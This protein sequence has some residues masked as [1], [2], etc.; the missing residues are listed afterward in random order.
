MTRGLVR[1]AALLVLSIASLGFTQ[2]GFVPTGSITVECDTGCRVEMPAFDLVEEAEPRELVSLGGLPAGPYDLT[3]TSGAGV[4]DLTLDVCGT[5]TPIRVVRGEVTVDAP[6]CAP[7]GYLTITLPT[8]ARADVAQRTLRTSTTVALY[9]GAYDVVLTTADGDEHSYTVVVSR[10][11]VT[12]VGLAPADTT[13]TFVGVPQDAIIRIS[14]AGTFDGPGPHAVAPGLHVVDVAAPGYAS[15][16]FTLRLETGARLERAIELEPLPP[17]FARIDV[18]PA[19]ATIEIDGGSY[20]SGDTITLSPGTFTATVTAPGHEATTTPLTITSET[21]TTAE[22]RLVEIL[23]RLVLS[24]EPD[25]AEVQVAGSQYTAADNIQLTPNTYVVLVTAPGFEPFEGTVDIAPDTDTVLEVSLAQRYV[26]TLAGGGS[27]SL[28]LRSDG[29]VWAWGSNWG[30]TLG[31]GTDTNRRTPVQ[32]TGLSDVTTISAGYG[33]SL[34]QRS[35]GTVWAWGQGSEGRLGDGATTNRATPVQVTGLSDVTAISAGYG[36]SLALR[37]DGTVWAWGRNR[38]GQLGDGTT[39]D[40]HVPVRVTGLSGVTAISAGFGHSLAQ[41]SDGTVWAWG[42]NGV[43][44]LG[45]GSATDRR[46][47]V[48][49]SGLSNATAVSAGYGFSLALRSDGTVWAWGRSIEGQLG[50]GTTN[51]RHTPVRVTGLSDVTAISAGRD[52]SLTLR[53]DGTVWAWGRNVEG[54]LGDS[55]VVA[56]RTHAQRVSGLSNLTGVSAGNGIS[57][58]LRSDGTVW[59][60]GWNLDGQLGDGTTTLRQTPGLVI[61][62]DA[63]QAPASRGSTTDR[64][65]TERSGEQTSPSAAATPPLSLW[66]SPDRFG[67]D[68]LTRVWADGTTIR[69]FEVPGRIEA[70]IE[71]THQLPNGDLGVVFVLAGLTPGTTATIEMLDPR[72]SFDMDTYLYLYDLGTG[73]IIADDDDSPDLNRSAITFTVERGVQYAAIASSWGGSDTGPF[74]LAVSVH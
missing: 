14:G 30:G 67:S 24:V 65:G 32:V 54:Q 69:P 44:Q 50:D 29:T 56:R 53:S 8:G 42:Q 71:S 4:W 70:S 34:A 2:D 20:A 9:V 22:V 37:S 21:T 28:A 49:V 46:T 73:Q 74:V 59:A 5:T 51:N 72:R 26:P 63:H 40:R 66:R 19:T 36:H 31:D 60:W 12:E 10:G 58:A 6:D 48:R 7:F 52:H 15:T 61:G 3:I 43:G 55:T 57:L 64:G 13:V 17:G 38:V 33:H 68:M 62:F 23:G 45:D 16:S 25:D 47:P 35:D 11:E 1:I 39:N 18:T 41:R 27:H